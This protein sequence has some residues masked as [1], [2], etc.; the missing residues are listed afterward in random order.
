VYIS[1]LVVIIGCAC[2]ACCDA[3]QREHPNQPDVETEAVNSTEFCV[4]QGVAHAS[5]LVVLLVVLS[6]AVQSVYHPLLHSP[7][8][9]RSIEYNPSAVSHAC[10]AH[11]L[12]DFLS[13]EQTAVLCCRC[14]AVLACLHDP[15][16]H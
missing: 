9:Q 4:W 1:V 3:W 11:C 15:I 16:N 2:A 7:V 6:G 13:P 5:P 12:S 8:L 14:S 10:T